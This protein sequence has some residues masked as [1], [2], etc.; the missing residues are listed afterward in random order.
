[1]RNTVIKIHRRFHGHRVFDPRRLG[2]S[3]ALPG[4]HQG[5]SCDLWKSGFHTVFCRSKS[6]SMTW[7][8]T[9]SE[10]PRASGIR[11]APARRE[12]PPPG[13]WYT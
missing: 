10:S 5:A 13:A 6:T 3:L 2:E 11:P 9:P 8:Q 4:W 7:H 1:M 12:P